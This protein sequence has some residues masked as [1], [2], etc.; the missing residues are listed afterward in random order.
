M[1]IS[2][3]WLI[4]I[5]LFV[6]Q[7]IYTFN[8]T[9]QI[10]YEELEE[11]VVNP[12][13]V[14]N[15]YVQ[16]GASG[17]LGWHFLLVGIY[18]IFGFDLFAA[19]YVKLFLY[20]LSMYCLAYMLRR[21]LTQK[22]AWLP[23][24]TIGLSPTFLYFNTLQTVYGIDI[25]YLPIVIFLV[26]RLRSGPSASLTGVNPLGVVLLWSFA[27]F[28][29]M[30][31]PAFAYYLPA[32]A[33]WYVFKLIKLNKLNKLIEL[34][35]YVALAVVSFLA[36]LVFAFAYIKN[37]NLLFYDPEAR[38]GIFRGAG[39]FDFSLN[40]FITNLKFNLIN[41]FGHSFGYYF[42]I[43]KVEFGDFYPILALVFVM[44]AVFKLWNKKP[45]LRLPIVLSCSIFLIN[46]M[47][48]YFTV[49]PTPGMRRYTGSL[50]A[51]YILFVFGWY[52]AAV[53]VRKNNPLRWVY[54][55][56]PT[57]ILVHQIFVYPQNLKHLKDASRYRE[58]VWFNT[59]DKPKMLHS[60]YVNTVQ[61]E[62]LKLICYGQNNNPL[63][64]RYSEVYAA[65]YAACL[66]NRLTC[67]GIFGWDLKTGKFIP[68]TIELFNEYYFGRYGK[69]IIAT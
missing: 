27:M 11:S 57:L 58:T 34:I 55:F 14:A 8:S 45:V 69:E 64:C 44:F 67:H 16:N 4:P 21:F 13:W 31:Y 51:I 1:K 17:N 36:P 23:L 25:L 49:D 19:K 63:N 68:L 47:L 35:K 61:R 38:S 18:S 2:W 42:E 46:V 33:L 15:G 10:R 3:Y 62:D 29:W 32:L 52:F 53:V 26:L 5:A 56:L 6:L 48:A 54:L 39:F 9:N 59:V 37:S 30:S 28:A 50:A 60:Q 20:L 43:N 12:Y 24:L 66:W 41:L 7:A 65:V 40:T 22:W